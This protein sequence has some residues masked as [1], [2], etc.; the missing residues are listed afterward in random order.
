[1][2]ESLHMWTIYDHPFDRPNVF[3]AR[4]WVVDD[5]GFRFTNET[6]EAST[7]DALRKMLPSGLTCISRSPS[8]DPKIVEAWL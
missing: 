6:I 1:V 3:I 5:K 2:R 8:D 7:L 4:L